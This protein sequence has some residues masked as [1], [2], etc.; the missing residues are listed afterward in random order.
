MYMLADA[1]PNS[2]RI[3]I[4]AGTLTRI[5]CA[6]VAAA[7]MPAHTAKVRMWPTRASQ[8]GPVKHPSTNPA[9]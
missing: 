2:A 3:A 7:A 9:K 8:R 5:D 6:N 1:K 4:Q